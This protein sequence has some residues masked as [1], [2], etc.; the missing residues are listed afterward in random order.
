MKRSLHSKCVFRSRPCSDSL[1]I[2]F[3]TQV[4]SSTVKLTEYNKL[5]LEAVG[6]GVGSLKNK[7]C[8][9]NFGGRRGS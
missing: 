9:L 3:P 6:V 8:K 2:Y 4:I 5:L 7:T 1:T